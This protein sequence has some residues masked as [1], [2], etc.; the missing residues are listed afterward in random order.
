[1]WY[2]NEHNWMIFLLTTGLSTFKMNPIKKS[3]N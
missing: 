3:L 2:Y 1:M